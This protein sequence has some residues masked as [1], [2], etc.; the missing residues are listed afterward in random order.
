MKCPQFSLSGVSKNTQEQ[1][2]SLEDFS[3]TPK[4]LLYFYPK[5][6]TPGCSN[7]AMDFTRLKKEFLDLG[8]QVVGVSPDSI[9]SHQN[10]IEK[11]ELDILLLSDPEKE[12]IQAIGAWGEKKNY[13][14]TYIG[15]IRSTFLIDTASGEIIE[16][17]KNVRAKGHGDRMLKLLSE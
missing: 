1:K 4:I 14:K 6:N 15:L 10:F 5:D 11:K 8:I 13:G 9:K 17:W 2:Y 12:L 7:Q 3:S 16:E